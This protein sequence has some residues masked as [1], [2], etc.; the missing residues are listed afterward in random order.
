MNA[1][2]I[3][4]HSH[5]C[6]I[7]YATDGE[8]VVAEA[9]GLFDRTQTAYLQRTT[10]HPN[11]AQGFCLLKRDEPIIIDSPGFRT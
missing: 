3:T 10:T 4:A 2:V 7:G 6:A 8:R 5:H 9:G 1:N 11:W